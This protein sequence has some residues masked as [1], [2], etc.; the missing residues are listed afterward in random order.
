MRRPCKGYGEGCL[1]LLLLK[2]NTGDSW[3]EIHRHA[4]CHFNMG[5]AISNKFATHIC[6]TQLQV[7]GLIQF[8]LGSFSRYTT[9]VLRDWALNVKWYLRSTIW[10][11]IP[12][13]HVKS[14]IYC[15]M[16]GYCVLGEVCNLVY[17]DWSL[18][19]VW[20]LRSIVWW[21]YNEC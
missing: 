20:S 8:S 18:H 3:H 21:Q 2:P 10:G 17:D 13:C 5:S 7:T 12:A 19:V 1:W 6:T 11:L 4:R 16:T 9:P 14:D 15:M